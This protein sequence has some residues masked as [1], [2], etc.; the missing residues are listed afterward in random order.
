MLLGFDFTSPRNFAGRMNTILP[1][2][3]IFTL[4]K[5]FSD[6]LCPMDGGIF[7]VEKTTPIR[8]EMFH[9]RAKVITQ[10]NF[11]LICSEMLLNYIEASAFD[12]FLHSFIQVLPLICPPSVHV[13]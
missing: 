9:H 10:N 2:D 3:I 11:V 13:N 7:I 6:P 5:P 8:I 12:M 4:I 1:K